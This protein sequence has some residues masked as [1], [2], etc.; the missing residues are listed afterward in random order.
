MGGRCGRASVHRTRRL[1]TCTTAFRRSLAPSAVLRVNGATPGRCTMRHDYSVVQGSAMIPQTRNLL[2]SVAT[3]LVFAL[4][5]EMATGDA[6]DTWFVSLEQP[7]YALSL[8]A[9]MVVGIAYYVTS[10]TVLFRVLQMPKRA[11]RKQLLVGVLVM[12]AGNELWTLLFFRLRSVQV[13]FLALLPFTALVVVLAAAFR[14]S[15]PRTAWLLYGYVV[16][17]VYDLVWAWSLW[18]RNP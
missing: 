1:G 13:G 7:W 12:M 14:A 8:P 2:V 10:G 9:W 4:L 18:Q 6:L 15:L 16:W 11:A 3:C 5:G 17:L